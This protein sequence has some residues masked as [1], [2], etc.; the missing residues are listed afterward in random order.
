MAFSLRRQYKLSPQDLLSFAESGVAVVQ[1]QPQRRRLFAVTAPTPYTAKGAEVAP[2][3]QVGELGSKAGGII[4]DKLP[5]FT[6]RANALRQYQ[7]MTNDD[8][9][10]DVSLRASKMPILGA[11]FYMEPADSSPQSDLIREFVEDNLFNRL[12]TPWLFLLEDILRFYEEGVQAFEKVFCLQEW[13]PSASGANR[14]N[15]T[16]LESIAVRPTMTLGKFNYDD[17]GRLVSVEQSALNADFSARNVTIPLEKLVVFTHNRKA[18]NLEGKSILRTAYKHWFYKNNLYTIDGIQ[19]ERHGTGFPVLTLP[20]NFTKADLEA[21]KE[22]VRNIRTNQESGAVLPPGFILTFAE[23]K[24]Q[25][26]DVMKSID[27][28]NG[29]IML[30]VM[31]AFLLTAVSESSSGGRASSASAQD[32]FIKSLRYIGNMICEIMN[33]EVIPQLVRYNFDVTMFPKMGVRS[34]GETK[35]FQQ[36]ASAVSNLLARNGITMDLPTEQFMRKIADFPLK[37]GDRQTPEAN[38]GENLQEILKG[39]APPE[40]TGGKQTT[41]G[42][43]KPD[44]NSGSGTSS[45]G[46]NPPQK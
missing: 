13:A 43:V 46:N 20:P 28:H 22:L 36:W 27:H 12:D 15:Y 32:M 30:N 4:P 42:D 21:A 40:D 17:N 41:K 23:M 3:T 6:S 19:K 7:T 39:D 34:I 38:K 29:M 45:V 37:I 26:V 18:G 2:S 8:A 1:T 33:N 14:K 11:D 44:G 31:V 24:N 16:M 9:A 35:D 5:L 10:V 25:P